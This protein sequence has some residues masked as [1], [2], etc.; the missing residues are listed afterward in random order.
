MLLLK[1]DKIEMVFRYAVFRPT[2]TFFAV[3]P[4]IDIYLYEY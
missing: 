3:Y 2:N 1:S 4:H